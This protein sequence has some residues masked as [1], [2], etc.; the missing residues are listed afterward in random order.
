[1][2]KKDRER[3]KKSAFYQEIEK[4]HKEYFDVLGPLSVALF[5]EGGYTKYEPGRMPVGSSIKTE[6]E[7]TE[8]SGVMY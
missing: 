4:V 1:M 6:L 7:D 3:I 5:G 8:R 2:G